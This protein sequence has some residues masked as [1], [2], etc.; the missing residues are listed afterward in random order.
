MGE[1]GTGNKHNW[2]AQYRQGEVK[3]SIGNAEAKD[4]ICATH[5]HELRCVGEMVECEEVQGRGGDKG[6]KKMGQL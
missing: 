6:K 5:G 1:R 4:I 3:I 2:Q